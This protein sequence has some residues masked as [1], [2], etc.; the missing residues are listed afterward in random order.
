M[1]STLPGPTV[2]EVTG[3]MLGVGNIFF[4]FTYI[5][6]TVPL[7]HSFIMILLSSLQIF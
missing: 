6:D 5:I 2:G 7:K 4:A 3:Y 1:Y